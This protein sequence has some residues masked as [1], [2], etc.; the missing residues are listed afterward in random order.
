MQLF[1]DKHNA[2]L[3]IW[4]T[5][6]V[7]TLVDTFTLKSVINQFWI[8]L[9]TMMYNKTNSNCNVI[10]ANIMLTSRKRK[11]VNWHSW[12]QKL[13]MWLFLNSGSIYQNSTTSII[14]VCYESCN[15]LFFR[16]RFNW[17]YFLLQYKQKFDI[18]E[19]LKN[20]LRF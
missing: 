20:N 8:N 6:M 7:C 2:F 18:R 16:K 14:I 13:T 11:E 4:L 10:N 12:A 3:H 17:R 5:R 15:T 9:W 1:L 19:Y